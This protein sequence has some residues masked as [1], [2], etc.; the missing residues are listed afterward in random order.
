MMATMKSECLGKLVDHHGAGTVLHLL[1]Q[2]DPPLAVCGA[3]RGNRRYANLTERI[4]ITV[5]FFS[6]W[7]LLLPSSFLFGGEFRAGVHAIDVTP[8]K[9]PVICNGGF[10]ERTEDHVEDPLHARCLV[11]SDGNMTIALAIVDSC[12]IPRDVCDAIKQ[13]VEQDCGIPANRI[14]IA[15]TH[16]HSAPS[17]M[18]FSLGSR[19]DA[20]YTAYLIPRVA[21]GI[22]R[23]HS[24]MEPARAGWTVVDAPNHTHCRRWIHR[25]NAFELDPFGERTVRAM[26][27]PG[28]KNPAYLMPAGPV[29]SS[30]TLLSI[31]S[32]DGRPIT[33]L[34]N[35]SMHYFGD[36]AGISADYFG[37]FARFLEQRLA[38]NIPAAQPFVGIMSQGTSGDL[39]WMNYA[40]PQRRGY[41]R[42]QYARELADIVMEALQG[43]TYRNQIDLAMEE[44][45]LTLTRRLPSQARL[46]WA[47]SVE[48]TRNGQRPRN[49]QEVYAEQA[50]WLRDNHKTELVLQ[51][52]C[53]GSLA[54]AAIPNE[55]FAITGLKLKEQ[56]P[57]QPLMNIELA[58]GAEGYIPP[59][60]QHYL[61]GYTT[62]PARTAGLETDAEPKI[63]NTLLGMLEHISGGAPRRALKTDYYTA[64][65]AAALAQA[66][67]DDNNR[68]NRGA[69]A[70][71]K[72]Q[73]RLE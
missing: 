30:L 45:H 47:E 1:F 21:A 55:V 36:S 71:S 73:A 28:Y 10:L 41:T 9:L 32:A 24:L 8:Q 31:Q 50:V 27:H 19:K 48:K 42:L 56:S 12:M 26:M 35:Y 11:I 64:D 66:R 39:H 18:D 13:R 61:G 5:L 70:G 72:Q 54:I 34:A 14:L 29:D 25:S 2:C 65:Q 49:L 7:L 62:W 59:P 6:Y 63:V 33:V 37:D 17:V 38:R 20:P 40:Q 22:V 60:E 46:D 52:I 3:I 68:E 53:I 57:I 69:V 23:A 16:T 51:A 4:R 15:A 58:N 44:A 43:I 67:L